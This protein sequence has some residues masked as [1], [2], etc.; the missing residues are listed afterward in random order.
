M[1]GQLHTRR[2]ALWSVAA[3]LACGRLHAAGTAPMPRIGLL[4]GAGFPE[5]ELAFVDELRKLGLI[6]DRDFV[7]A[8]RFAHHDTPEVSQMG[9]Q[10]AH[11]LQNFQGVLSLIN[12]QLIVDFAATHRI[13]AIYQSVPFAHS[14]GLMTWAPVQAEQMR[15]AARLTARILAGA[16]P[17]DLPVAFPEKYFLTLNTLAAARIG[18]EF[19]RELASR[20]D[21]IIARAAIRP[22]RPMADGE[23]RR[24][25]PT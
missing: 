18:L 21:K 5:L 12:R 19:P 1:A 25:A 24:P 17:G 10:L 7:L 2:T 11:G 15:I 8:R 13:P 14:G 23:P 16:S 3:A 20:A 22:V 4:S 6:E 9:A